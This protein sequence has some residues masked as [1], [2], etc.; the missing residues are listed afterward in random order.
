MLKFERN[1]TGTFARNTSLRTENAL[2]SY[3]DGSN[4]KSTKLK[5]KNIN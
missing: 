4:E 3:I 2:P 5:R 1:L